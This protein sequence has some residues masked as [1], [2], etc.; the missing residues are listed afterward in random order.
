MKQSLVEYAQNLGAKYGVSNLNLTINY[1]KD[2]PRYEN[3]S[4][5]TAIKEYA[6]RQSIIGNMND[7]KMVPPKNFWFFYKDNGGGMNIYP[8]SLPGKDDDASTIF[9]SVL[10]V[11]HGDWS[12]TGRVPGSVRLCLKTLVLSWKISTFFNDS[13]WKIL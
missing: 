13:K 5:N 6:S 8:D 11:W 9:D 1:E 2:D 10:H 3:D 4:Y 12:F 7:D